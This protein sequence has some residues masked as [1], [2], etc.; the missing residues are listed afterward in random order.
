MDDYGISKA[1]CAWALCLLCA[2]GAAPAEDVVDDMVLIDSIQTQHESLSIKQPPVPDAVLQQHYPIML[3]H[4]MAGFKPIATLLDYFY[5]V[6]PAVTGDG[7]VVYASQ[8]DPFQSIDYRARQLAVQVDEALRLTG[9][10]KMHLVAH[11]QGGLDAR[12]LVSSLGY[13]DRVATLTTIATPHH[14]VKL[15]D[16]ALRLSPA[17][18][19]RIS[20][21]INAL[22]D[23]LLG[24]NADMFAQLQDLTHHAMTTQFNPNNPDDPRVEYFSYA[25]TTQSYPFVDSRYVDVVNP[26]LYPTYQLLWRVEGENDGV[27]G[28]DSARWGTYLGAFPA[29][30]WDEI[31]QPPALN[32]DSF[33]H[34]RFYRDLTAFLDTNTIA[35]QY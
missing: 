24:G 5:K 8:C 2:C 14:G 35:P 6:R 23:G 16:M 25:G 28:V 4:G 26:L 1:L 22:S 3:V 13:G 10:S 7:F 20:R 19:A 9:A 33:N 15:V 29:D 32:H 31:G 11:S 17:W 21:I 34:L 12:Y 18:V 27:V 30:H